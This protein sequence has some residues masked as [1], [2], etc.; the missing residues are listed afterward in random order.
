MHCFTLS[1]LLFAQIKSNKDKETKVFYSI[2][3]QGADTPPVGVFV[4]DRETGKLSVTKPLDREDIS[5]YVTAAQYQLRMQATDLKGQ[6]LRTTATAVIKVQGKDESEAPSSSLST[7]VLNTLTGRPATAL[8]VHLSRLEGPSLQWKE[9]TQSSTNAAGRCPSLLAP[10]QVRAG[11]YRL[12]FDT[13]A[14]WRQQG[15]ASGYP[16]VEVVFTVT[17]ETQKLHFP[18]LISPFSYTTYQGS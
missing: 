10:E 9:L 15:Y 13:G 14:Y 1:L 5:R 18:L 12:R 16:Y 4:I 11:T 2:T 17:E 8:A 3:G 6:G 7:Q